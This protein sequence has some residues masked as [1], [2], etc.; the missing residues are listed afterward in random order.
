MYMFLGGGRGRMIQE[1]ERRW[2]E[3][4]KYFLFS[5]QYARKSQLPPSLS[6][7]FSFS[8][9]FS[10]LH[11]EMSCL[12]VRL[13]GYSVVVTRPHCHTDHAHC[14][15]PLLLRAKWVSPRVVH[16]IQILVLPPLRSLPPPQKK[17]HNFP[18]FFPLLLPLCFSYSLYSLFPPT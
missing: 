16:N 15:T 9:W 17:S 8:K 1:G 2:R 13:M 7:S 10:S 6:F 4:G 11:R 18:V 5:A 14:I 3:N 12:A